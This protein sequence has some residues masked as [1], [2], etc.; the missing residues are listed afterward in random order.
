MPSLADLQGAFAAALRDPARRVPAAVVVGSEGPRARGFD[1][2]R[3][4]VAVSLTEALQAAFPVVQRLVGDD[5]FKAAAKAYVAQEP[6]R[7]PVLLLYGQGFGDFLDGFP[8]AQ[9]VPYLSDVARLEW[10]RLHAYHAADAPV[11]EISRLAEI[12]EAALGGLRFVLHPSL[13]LVRSR[14]PVV[15]I[16]AASSGQGNA[17]AVDMSVA[18]EAAVIRP[19][20]D[21]DLR[22]LPPGGYGFMEALM[23]GATLAEAAE[24]A[25]QQDTAFALAEHLQGLFQIG[26]VTALRQSGPDSSTRT[27]EP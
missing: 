24:R 22:L 12:P 13:R 3:N 1:V 6:P 23:T 18:Q 2:Y 27:D 21:V 16:W 10:A 15:S 7:S 20:L 4:N 26:A 9:E 8:P 17:E 19:A 11:L 25:S 5:F 14:W